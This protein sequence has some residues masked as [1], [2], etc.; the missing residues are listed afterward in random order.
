MIRQTPPKQQ[1]NYRCYLFLCQ[2]ALGTERVL[3]VLSQKW[4]DGGF[5]DSL[6]VLPEGR[7]ITVSPFAGRQ[8]VCPVHRGRFT[9]QLRLANMNIMV[10]CKFICYK[11][12][13][14]G[15]CGS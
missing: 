10:S 7:T 3:S 4:I 14:N 15:I 12:I 9:N 13:T 5:T 2:K 8:D 11:M 6:P 1:D